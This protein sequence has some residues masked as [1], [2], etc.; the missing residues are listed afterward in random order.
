MDS[1]RIYLQEALSQLDFAKRSYTEFEQALSENDTIS[2]FYRLHHFIVH[3]ANLDKLLD[4][5]INSTRNKL[6]NGRIDLSNIDLKSIRRLRNHLEHFDE[7]LDKWVSKHDGS[8]FFDMNVVT[9]ASGFPKNIFLRALDGY[10][11]KFYGE[12]YQLV[13]IHESLI[14]LEAKLLEHVKLG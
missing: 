4:T 1:W 7:R 10:T 6:I 3:V 2:V 5:D 12:D 14:V 9:N 8:A 11:F 13:E